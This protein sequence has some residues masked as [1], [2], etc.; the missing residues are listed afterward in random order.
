M[1]FYTIYSNLLYETFNLGWYHFTIK[2]HTAPL[3]AWSNSLVKASVRS[4]E[5][6]HYIILHSVFIMNVLWIRIKILKC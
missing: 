3:N 2:L 5:F 4:C 6:L 1:C